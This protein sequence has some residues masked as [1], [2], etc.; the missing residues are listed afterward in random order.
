MNAA[1]RA[2]TVLALTKGCE[3]LGVQRGYRGLV[4]GDFRPL[5][6]EDVR[7][8]HR[9]GGTILGSARCLEFL[10]RG[11][12]EQARKHL[13]REGVEGLIVIGG[14][15]SLAGAQ[16]L[17]QPQE[18][19]DQKL[20]V[21]GIPASIDNDLGLTSMS[22]GV[23]TAL[24]TIVDAC[25]KISDTASAHERTFVVEVMGR[26]CGYLAMTAAVAAGADGVL[27]PES[28]PSESEVVDL[29]VRAALSTRKR[30]G[31]TRALILKA[32]GVGVPN[33]RLRALV[34]ARLRASETGLEEDIETRIT[35]LGHVVRGGR[36]T[37]FDRLLGSRLANVAVEA[38][39][40]GKSR[41]MASW[42]PAGQIPGGA[43]ACCDTDPYCWL[44]DIGAVLEET[45]ALLDG[46]SALSKWRTQTFR[47]IEDALMM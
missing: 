33:D 29:I 21:V 5:G 20:R 26:D 4:Q 32:E 28:K 17:T 42:M 2:T 41:L 1:V 24:N 6:P 39:L 8:I 34:D 22:I 40:R 9:E 31:R 15:G 35:V 3:V 37:A 7:H 45:N 46:T 43:G 11:P 36:P 27:F 10:D 47:A 14:N 16:A 19:G 18:L 12:R 44:M 13:E 38:L 25:G 30:L 23:D